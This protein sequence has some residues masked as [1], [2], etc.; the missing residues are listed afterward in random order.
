MPLYSPLVPDSVK[1]VDLSKVTQP[2]SARAGACRSRVD[3]L[4]SAP[5][6]L[7]LGTRP[8]SSGND[9]LGR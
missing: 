9:E 8:S 2:M 1:G 3:A 6:G 4:R 7:G 5:R